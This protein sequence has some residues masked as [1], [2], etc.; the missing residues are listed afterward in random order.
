LTT[1]ASIWLVAAIG[2]AVGTGTYFLA[3]FATILSMISLMLLAPVSHRLEHR[4]EVRRMMDQGSQKRAA[5]E[6][7]RED[8]EAELLD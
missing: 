6:E 8:S 7:D 3:A 4:A 1:A 5:E 2:M